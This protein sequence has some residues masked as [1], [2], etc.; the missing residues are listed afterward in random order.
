VRFVRTLCA[1]ALAC[2]ALAV[3]AGSAGA[4]GAFVVVIDHVNNPRGLAFAPNGTLY[5]AA[6]GRA[7]TKCL[8]PDECV[9]LTS[10][11]WKRANGKN[12]QLVGSLPSAGGQDGSF[13]VGVDG[14][15]VAPDGSVFAIETSAG[16]DGLPP[17][18]PPRW[19]T[20]GHLLRIWPDGRITKVAAIDQYE[21]DHNPDGAQLDSDPYGV[22]ALSA[23]R[24]LVADAAGN[25]VLQVVDGHL[26]TFAVFPKNQWGGESVPTSLAKGPDG[27]IYVGELGGEGTRAGGSR[28]WRVV[29]GHKPTVF[30]TGFTS[31][32]GIAFGADG[33]LYVTELNRDPV[34][35]TPDGDIVRVRPN[36]A[37]TRMGVGALQFPAG[38]AIGPGG[39]VFTSNW[40]ILPAFTSAGGPFGGAHG[41]VVRVT[42]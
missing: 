34:N 27:A 40:S 42:S 18:F 8:G 5:A 29:P 20:L 35:F 26:S 33:S 9:G 19:D 37:R 23:H 31:I 21:W 22:L 15:S 41:Q 16:Q 10:A 12:S 7:G 11:I 4:S 13:T 17:G 6:A 32:T 28:V 3:S 25:D 30:R 2:T 36:G 24:Q 1:C 39:G 14:V 38:L